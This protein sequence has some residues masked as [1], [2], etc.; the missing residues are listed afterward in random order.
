M[1]ESPR[2]S[3]LRFAAEGL[4][5]VVSILLALAVDTYWSARQDRAVERTELLGI[6]QQLME[7]KTELERAVA[8][9]SLLLEASDRLVGILE[10]APDGTVSVV[11]SL[12]LAQGE[13][14]MFVAPL[15]RIESLLASGHVVLIE[16]P[17]LRAMITGWPGVAAEVTEVAVRRRDFYEAEF[18]T[19]LRDRYNLNDFVGWGSEARGSFREIPVDNA[20]RNL[21]RERRF[22]DRVLL[23]MERRTLE[24]LESLLEQLRQ[25]LPESV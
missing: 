16:D 12:L 9:D 7:T 11:D 20:F 1:T 14:T 21:L 22:F 2:P 25:A 3:R 19:H 10:D 5:I 24:H 17:D 6:Q 18:L 8:K 15:S 13:T 4:V 23:A